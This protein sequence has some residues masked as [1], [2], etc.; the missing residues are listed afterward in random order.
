MLYPSGSTLDIITEM[1]TIFVAFTFQFNAFPIYM[2]L[3]NKEN[4]Q[5]IKATSSGVFFCLMVYIITGVSGFL[6]YREKLTNTVLDNLRGEILVYKDTNLFIFIILIIINISFLISSTMS[7]PLMFFSLK[8]NFLN[9]II[10]C[11]KNLANKN[12]N[13]NVNQ[14]EDK[15]TIQ[16][17]I[18]NNEPKSKS[19]IQNNEK[20]ILTMFLYISLCVIT[21]TVKELKEVFNIVGSTAGNAINYI[22]P[23]M[24]LLKLTKTKIFSS[25][26]LVSQFLY[27]IG[28]LVLFLC[29]S[30]EIVKI[31]SN[32][33]NVDN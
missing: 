11:K 23:N 22:F 19:L 10:F 21:I 32:D 13:D 15:V 28:V 14:S 26:N 18:D 7:I 29:L 2:S 25:K 27:I 20:I 3:K 12:S 4:K 30:S 5:M 16:P 8:R 1:P 31:S 33:D 9:L 24:F 17:L 6:M